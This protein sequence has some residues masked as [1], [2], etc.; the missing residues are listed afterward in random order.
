[1]KIKNLFYS[2]L[3]VCLALLVCGGA[4]VP[5]LQFQAQAAQLRV[6]GNNDGKLK[7]EEL[8]EIGEKP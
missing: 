5:A 1:M 2:F 3:L 7:G 4:T 6:A 8:F